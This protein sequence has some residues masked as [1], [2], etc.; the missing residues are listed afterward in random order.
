MQAKMRSDKRKKPQMYEYE[1]LSYE[2]C[3][4]LNNH[5]YILDQYLNI[6][7]VKITSVKTW[8][9]RDDVEIRCK[10]GMYEFFTVEISSSSPNTELIKLVEKEDEKEDN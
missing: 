8:K 7:S 10:Y 4:A 5:A 9:T 3:R 2:E 6:A 1:Y